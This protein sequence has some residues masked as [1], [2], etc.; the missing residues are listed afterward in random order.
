MKIK[1]WMKYNVPYIPPKCRKTRYKEN[2]EFFE[3]EIKEVSKRK[4]LKA[5]ETKNI[6]YFYNDKLWEKA[7]ESNIHCCNPD[8]PMTALNALIYSGVTYSTYFGKY[9]GYTE[10]T[11][12]QRE[13]VI[14]RIN[15]DMD[16]YI[17]VDGELYKTTNEPM[18]CI[19][20][21]GLGH[22]HAG[23]GTS[24]SIMNYY[25]EN[26]SSERYYNALDYKKALKEALNIAKNRGDTDSIEFIKNEP[27]IKVFNKKYV[28]RFPEKEHGQGSELLNNIESIISSSNNSIEAGLLSIA[29]VGLKK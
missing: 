6:I 4:L 7:N 20:T 11:R 15:Q 26:I 23:I 10:D 29:M 12:E 8:K 5:F 2:E 3:A 21:F 22:N 25:N 27:K 16:Q 13:D 18:Y 28:T 19:Y 17:I 9:K 1:I 14:N 24:L